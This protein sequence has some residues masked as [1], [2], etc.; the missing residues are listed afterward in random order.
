MILFQALG[1][2]HGPSVFRCLGYVVV[3]KTML[4]VSWFWLQLKF[5]FYFS[6]T[7]QDDYDWIHDDYNNEGRRMVCDM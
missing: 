3:E 6:G 5:Y 7:F 1:I 4:G 2:F